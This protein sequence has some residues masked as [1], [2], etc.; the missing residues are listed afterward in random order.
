MATKQDQSRG[1]SR[2]AGGSAFVSALVT[3]PAEVPD[4]AR[5]VGYR[6]ASSEEGFARLYLNP[7]LNLYLEIPEEDI[8]LARPVP[9]AADP[10]GAVSLWVRRDS[11][12]R[13]KSSKGEAD[14][15]QTIPTMGTQGGG[16]EA[17]GGYPTL[18]YTCITTDPVSCG[19]AGAGAQGTFTPLQCTVTPL[20]PNDT[21]PTFAAQ[22]GAEAQGATFPTIDASC[23]TYGP[24][25]GAEAMATFTPI[26]RTPP[27]L[28]PVT[29]QTIS[30][31][32]PRTISPLTPNT[33]TPLTRTVTPQTATPFTPQTA[34]PLTRTATPFTPQTATP[35]TRTFTPLT[36][37]TATP[38]TRTVTP[39]TATP[40]TPQTATPL[41]RTVTPITPGTFG[42]TAAP[43]GATF[44][45]PSMMG[46]QDYSCQMTMGQ[47]AAGF[48]PTMD[49]SCY[50]YGGEGGGGG[51][52]A[53]ATFT[54]ITGGTFT[55]ISRNTVTPISR[56]TVTPISRNTVTPISRNTFT[57]VSPGTFTPIT[58]TPPT[59][60]TFTPVT[61][62]TFT[63]INFGAAAPQG[64][65]FFDP[66]MMGTQDPYSCQ[67][68]VGGQEAA[69][70]YPT[71]DASCYGYGGEG[72]GGGA[73]AMA[74]FTPITGGTFTPI[75]PRTVTPFTR[76]PPT[77][78]TFTPITR[79]PPTLGT[80]TPITRTP[81]TPGTFTPATPRTITT[82]PFNDP[83]GG[84][85]AQAAYPTMDPQSCLLTTVPPYTIDPQS[86]LLTT[87]PP[88]GGAEAMATFTPITTGSR[89][90]LTPITGGN[91]ITPVSPGTFTP[92]TRTPP[93]P[94]TFTPITR[95]PPTPGTFTPVTRTPPTPGTF[96]PITRTPPT[97]GTFTPVT[98]RT[99]TPITFND[100][101]G[102]GAGAQAAYPTMDPSCA[103]TMDPFSCGGTGGA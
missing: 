36:P 8:L 72:G 87:I 9:P 49:A 3:D 100:P 38:L 90:T 47:E 40:F 28:T 14:M 55:P 33:A 65:T 46:T 74:T 43:Q 15:S 98:P 18:D 58:R 31:V 48:Y 66:S 79:T 51:A 67:I 25:G 27:T 42:G 57:P 88:Q 53:M 85:A 97:P 73:E 62:G 96:T 6:G 78:G 35:L 21:L 29:P 17:A 23:Y 91:T 101:A 64:A 13:T 1:P 32:S 71:M 68:T 37:Q 11:K 30:P 84:A 102:G 86:C 45:D 103:F 76:T 99:I 60:G 56:N 52:E 10:L 75:S 7:E 77:P 94:G 20:C 54:P 4:V 59:P 26:T 83:S 70:F 50:G 12:I 82:I 92:I 93:T 16:A 39:Q 81:P 22:G 95:T 34:T 80:F 5:F 63:P 2:A 19:G 61:R 69:G 24:Q 89:P 41:T 44:F